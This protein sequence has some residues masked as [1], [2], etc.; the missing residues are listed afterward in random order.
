MK[1]IM[2][3]KIASWTRRSL[4][5]FVIM[6]ALVYWGFSGMEDTFLSVPDMVR[7]IVKWI[8]LLLAILSGIFAILTFLSFRNSKKHILGL[9]NKLQNS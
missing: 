9:I 4:V 5:I 1:N 3:K 8:A 6:I 7:D 2:T